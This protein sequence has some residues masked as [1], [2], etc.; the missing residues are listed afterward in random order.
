MNRNVFVWAAVVALIALPALAQKPGGAPE[1]H[2]DPNF[3]GNDLGPSFPGQSNGSFILVSGDCSATPGCDDY[4]DIACAGGE[5]ITGSFC[6]NGG[7]ADFDTGISTWSGTT[8]LDCNDDTCGLQAEL[9]TVLPAAP[10]TYRVRIGGFGGDS[11]T[12]T[13][14]FQAP[15]TCSIVGGVP[16]TLQ[17]VD[18][19]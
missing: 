10:G 11:G 1:T 7:T 3:T 6:S 9:T 16:V 13:L 19:E 2:C 4:F 17:S 14:A 15:A 5:T 8:N 18:V 12:Y